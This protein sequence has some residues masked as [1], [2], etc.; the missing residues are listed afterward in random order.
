M[1]STDA[2]RSRIVVLFGA[3]LV[4]TGC[5]HSIV[6]NPDE[7]FISRFEPWRDDLPRY[8]FLPGDELDIKLTYTP[9]FSDRVIVAPD[10]NVYMSLIGAVKAVGRTVD[11]VQFELQD[12]FSKELKYPETAVIP[13]QFDSQYVFVGGEVFNPGVHKIGYETTVLQAVMTAGG[14]Q[15]TGQLD[16]VILIRRTPDKK[17]MLR[18]IDLEAVLEG[19]TGELWS[20]DVSSD[21]VENREENP[22]HGRNPQNSQ[23]TLET[24]EYR[25]EDILLNRFD[26]IFVPRTTI[27]ELNIIISQYI[28]NMVPFN[29]TVNYTINRTQA[30]GF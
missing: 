13:R 10:G 24:A 2:I 1:K 3:L 15:N 16:K 21:D 12:R 18:V 14:V 26:V 30:Q 29:P 5:M 7:H 22:Y 11:E 23:E 4:L 27:A 20:R 25:H 19:E 28:N 9:E 6:D 17:A 8:T